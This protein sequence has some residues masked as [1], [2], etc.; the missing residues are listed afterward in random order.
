MQNR[1]DQS[2][3]RCFSFSFQEDILCTKERCSFIFLQSVMINTMTNFEV[4]PD[5]ITSATCEEAHC[6]ANNPGDF[7]FCSG[8]TRRRMNVTSEIDRPGA[9]RCG[10]VDVNWANLFPE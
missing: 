1:E 3:T 8:A 5:T 7:V 9:Q 10:I 2:L 6:E 4:G